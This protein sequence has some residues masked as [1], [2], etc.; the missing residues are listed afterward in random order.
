MSWPPGVTRQPH[1]RLR[2]I[3]REVNIDP[4]YYH[5]YPF[6][7]FPL[8]YPQFYAGHER[9][10]LATCHRHRYLL[11]QLHKV[12]RRQNQQTRWTFTQ[13][14]N[15]DIVRVVHSLVSEI[16]FT[17]LRP[18]LQMIGE[19]VPLG[20]WSKDNPLGYYRSV[21]LRAVEIVVVDYTVLYYLV[22]QFTPFQKT[23]RCQCS[24]SANRFVSSKWVFDPEWLPYHIL[25]NQLKTVL[26]TDLVNLIEKWYY[27]GP[28]PTPS[29][30][31]FQRR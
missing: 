31:S 14:L 9:I 10:E 25:R 2:R 13:P 16:M 22:F 1:R 8:G 26:P 15:A 27:T 20:H 21:I 29:P 6:V 19:C 12:F 4:I 24:P 28:V 3:L 5:Y 18:L 23:V 11:K 30:P 7:A 17:K